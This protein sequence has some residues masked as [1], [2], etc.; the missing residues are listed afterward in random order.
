M[1]VIYLFF[2]LIFY[3]SI[4]SISNNNNPDYLHIKDSY[5]SYNGNKGVNLDFVPTYEK[6]LVEFNTTGTFP[7]PD[8][9]Q[10]RSIIILVFGS[11][12]I[13]IIFLILL[14]RSRKRSKSK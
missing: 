6:L 2:I 5:V 1:K 10:L 12:P 7:Y 3:L 14:Y 8:P 9:M 4:I 11:I 13:G